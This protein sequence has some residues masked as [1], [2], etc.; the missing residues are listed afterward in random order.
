MTISYET[1]RI[2]LRFGNILKVILPYGKKNIPCRVLSNFYGTTH[3]VVPYGCRGVYQI[4]RN[5]RRSFPTAA[6]GF[7]RI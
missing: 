3:K 2:I 7:Y 5:D 6:V 1:K 4:L